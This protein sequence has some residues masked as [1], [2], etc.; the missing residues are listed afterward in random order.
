LTTKE[1]H[2]VQPPQELRDLTQ[3][4]LWYYE[5]GNKI[6]KQVGGGNAKSNDPGTWSE[7]QDV[8][9]HDRIAFEITAPYT[10]IDLDN[11]LD[12]KGMLL[13][14]AILLVAK[15][16]G[17][18]FGEVSP[19]GRGIKFIT[20]ARKP[21]GSRCKHVIDAELGQQIE[22]YD[23]ARFWTITGVGYCDRLSD[24]QAAVDSI[25]QGYLS[26][27]SAASSPLSVP[28]VSDYSD[29]AAVFGSLQ[30]RAEAYIDGMYYVE[31]GGRNDACFKLAGHLWS[32]RDG[33]EQLTRG[34]VIRYVQHWNAILP[35]PLPNAEAIK[36]ANSGIDNGTARELKHADEPAILIEEVEPYVKSKETGAVSMD[37]I[38]NAPGM[39][40][41]IYRWLDATCLYQL[42]EVFLASALAL[43]SLI[44][45]RKV[46]GP[47]NGRTNLYLLSMAKTGAGKEHGRSRIK[48]M[49][50][51]IEADS[52][53]S[54]ESLASG[55]GLTSQLET[56]PAILFQL[57]E[58]G[59]LMV[60]MNA[61]NAPAHLSGIESELLKLYS[62][63]GDMWV[64]K[65]Y[66]DAEKVTRI[67]Q[68]HVVING[69][70]T[71]STLWDGV[72]TK[73]VH[74]G[75]FGR[76]QVFE[77]LEYVP[78]RD[79]LPEDRDLIPQQLMNDVRWW[80]D[81]QPP[82]A[83]DLAA[84]NPKPT[85]MKATP[86]A[87]KRL[88]NHMREIA[89][90]RIGEDD[91]RAAVWSRSAEKAVKLAML[92]ACAQKRFSIELRDV[93]WA[94]ALQ[95]QLTRKMAM[96]IKDH[97]AENGYEKS[98]K[99]LMKLI[100]T[101]VKWAQMELFLRA[102]W[103]K[104]ERERRD[105]LDDLEACGLIIR[106]TEKTGKR[107]RPPVWIQALNQG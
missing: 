57:D 19:S 103:F 67:S 8:E 64:G 4:H 101:K 48:R 25:C 33:S 36:A 104:G 9:R 49:F 51:A 82:G 13:D 100:R 50:E 102:P 70:C 16:E 37:L 73:Q 6:P 30:Q 20:R 31:E 53:L 62:A 107:G 10:G 65:A 17:V 95:N 3:W 81:Y 96:R 83:G 89:I 78:V 66:A 69:T 27:D 12:K 91:V 41:D 59:Q 45:G 39:I 72:T 32:F 38:E 56:N 1:N 34:E 58:F 94:I 23:H 88:E 87:S 79:V 35:K 5:D 63:S 54:P 43:M 11:C 80:V 46:S 29:L 90:E 105:V 52:F 99:R 76:L 61:H 68:P 75:L 74:S 85:V 21:E 22:V 71:P 18:S 47:W 106:T 26:P 14:W 92:A 86:E 77:S 24:G 98:K 28:S 40:G 55:A 97:V 93:D 44:T 2:T 84:L 60:S 15:L 42:P 7:Y